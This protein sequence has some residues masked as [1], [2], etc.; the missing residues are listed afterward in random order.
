MCAA[1][2]AHGGDVVDHPA[3]RRQ[4][5]STQGAVALSTEV[6]P[7]G[8]VADGEP[9]FSGSMTELYVVTLMMTVPLARVL[10][11][12]THPARSAFQNGGGLLRSAT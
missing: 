4:D 11:R 6:E 5:T 3:S 7:G 10:H 2:I 1:G 9:A 12:I 8:P